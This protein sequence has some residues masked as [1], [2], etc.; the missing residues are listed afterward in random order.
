MLVRVWKKEKAELLK[1]QQEENKEV[2][3]STGD[4]NFENKELKPN[5]PIT[6]L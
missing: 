4:L 2:I 3:L 6:N 5:I 1:K